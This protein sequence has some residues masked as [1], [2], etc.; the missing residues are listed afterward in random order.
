MAPGMN[1]DGYGRDLDALAE[2]AGQHDLT[3]KRYDALPSWWQIITGWIR[4][5]IP[6]RVT[7]GFNCRAWG[8]GYIQAEPSLTA[9]V[10]H[11]LATRH[12]LVHQIDRD[13]RA[14]VAV[15]EVEND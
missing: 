1:A 13:T 9:A 11:A 4:P 5:L 8:C 6:P 2:H 10:E 7:P 12:V 3:V 15:M 14:T